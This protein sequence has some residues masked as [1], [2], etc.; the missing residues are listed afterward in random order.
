MKTIDLHGFKHEDVDSY[1][2]QEIESIWNAGIDVE[3]ITG[4]SSRMKHIVGNILNRY[5]L[6]Y[7]V[8]GFLKINNGMITTVI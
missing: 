1:L 2:T 7:E 3:I 8:G 5:D 4:H 6:N